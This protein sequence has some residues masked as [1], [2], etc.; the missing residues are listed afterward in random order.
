MDLLSARQLANSLMEKHGVKTQG[1]RFAFDDSVAHFG[2]CSYRQKVIFL[3]RPMTLTITEEKVTDTILHEI[4]HI[5]CP[6]HGHDAEW[7]RVA[8]SIG[9]RG[10]RC[11]NIANEAISETRL[12][13]FKKYKY[14]FTYTCPQCNNVTYSNDLWRGATCRNGHPAVNYKIKKN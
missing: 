14:N 4:A 2:L 13:K 12:E 3:S 6:G 7:K 11:G 8:K 1:W 9:C 5:L 10:E